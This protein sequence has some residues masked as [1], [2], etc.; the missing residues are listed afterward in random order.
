MLGINIVVTVLR[1]GSYNFYNCFEMPQWPK[2]EE[3][4]HLGGRRYPK[5]LPAMDARL[6]SSR[7]VLGRGSSSLWGLGQVSELLSP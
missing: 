5:V 1:W 3:A 4:I 2:L 6:S 7:A